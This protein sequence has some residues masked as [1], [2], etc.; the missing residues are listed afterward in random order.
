ML[1][2][3]EIVGIRP[4]DAADLVDIAEA[5]GD[6]ERGLGALALQDGIDGDGGAVEKQSSGLVIAARLLNPGVDPLDQPLRR[7]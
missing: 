6:E 4:V 3:E 7:R 5:L 2:E 1:A